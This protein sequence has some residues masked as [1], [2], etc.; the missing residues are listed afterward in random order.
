MGEQEDGGA[1]G[2]HLLSVLASAAVVWAV[3]LAPNVVAHR[4]LG[5][6]SQDTSAL[7]GGPAAAEGPGS[8]DWDAL[9]CGRRSCSAP[10]HLDLQGRTFAAGAG[11]HQ[12]VRRDDVSTRTLRWTVRLGTRQQH[13]V[14]VGA[15]GS[16]SASELTVQLGSAPLVGVPHG[17]LTL[18]QVP[19]Q[20]RSVRIS[21]VEGGR[22]GAETLRIQEYALGPP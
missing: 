3:L 10:A 19:A 8:R 20:G 2:A 9:V 21:L 14:L 11:T 17:R 12:R 4:H 22:S 6:P 16:S 5:S 18:L 15:E 1:G 7:A 13:W